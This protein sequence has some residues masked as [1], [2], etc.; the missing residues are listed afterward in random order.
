MFRVGPDRTRGLTLTACA[1]GGVRTHTLSRVGGFKP[2]AS[3]N[4]ATR[5]CAGGYPSVFE[6]A[7]ATLPRCDPRRRV[8]DRAATAPGRDDDAGRSARRRVLE[9]RACGL[10]PA[11]TLRTRDATVDAVVGG[12]RR[13]GS[14]RGRAR[15]RH[16][17]RATRL[18]RTRRRHHRPRV[19]PGACLSLARWGLAHQP[20]RAGFLWLRLRRLQRHGAARRDGSRRVRHHRFRP[21]RCRPVGWLALPHRRRGRRL[22]VPRLH[23][24]HTGR[25]GTSR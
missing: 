22:G 19:G 15:V 14:H 7:T 23:T 21:T 24:R 6:R 12:V 2:P 25:A 10:R 20:G 3:A 16:A 4:S 8:D 13:P 5:A 17:H 1:R 11:V 9:R 18:R